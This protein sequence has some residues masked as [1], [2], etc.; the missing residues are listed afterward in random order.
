MEPETPWKYKARSLHEKSQHGLELSKIKK[1]LDEFEKNVNLEKLILECKKELSS[2][3]DTPNT[4]TNKPKPK[5]SGLL[6]D[7]N[8]YLSNNVDWS[9]IHENQTDEIGEKN[10][11]ELSC[12]FSRDIIEVCH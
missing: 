12:C 3:N 7:F 9:Q 6:G 2:R 5:P 11:I 1:T 10:K 8:D 4:V